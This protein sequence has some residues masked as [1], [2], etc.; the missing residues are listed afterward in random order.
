MATLDP[1]IVGG[2]GIGAQIVRDQ[3]IGNKAVFLQEFAHQ[4]QRGKLVSLG[5]EEHIEHLA[6]SVDGAPQSDHLASDFQMRF[7][8]MLGRAEFRATL[9]QV[10]REYW[11][12]IIHPAPNRLV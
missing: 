4:F 11:V 2:G 3:P 6:L 12:E 9:T 1:Q 8:E 7:V 5:L 10:R